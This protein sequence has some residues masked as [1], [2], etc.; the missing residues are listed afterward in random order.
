V[1]HSKNF[2]RRAGRR[3]LV[4]AFVVSTAIVG[5]GIA[6]TSGVG[7]V[8]TPSATLTPIGIAPR[9][10]IGVHPLGAVAPGRVLSVAVALRPRHL[11]ELRAYVDAI[12][13]PSSRLYH[14]YLTPSEFA[15]K[16][17]PPMREVRAI[18]RA[19]HTSH[20][21]TGPV[22]INRLVIPVRGRVSALEGFFHTQLRGYRERDGNYGW[23]ATG[24]PHV[25]REVAPSVSAVIGLDNVVSPHASPLFARRGG[26]DSGGALPA[27]APA[28]AGAP[29]AC[30]DAL[31]RAQSD[32][33]WTE[34][35]IAHAYGLDR[36][37]AEGGLGA[38]QTIDLME[39]EPFLRSDLATFDRCFFGE[40]HT[41]QVNAIPVDGFNLTG[42]GSGESLL[43]VEV[44][45]A[46]APKATIDVYEAPNTSYG[47]IDAY[48]EM[49]NSDSANVISTSWGECETVIQLAAPGTQQVENYLFEE[50]AAQGQTVFAAS[51][52]SGSDDCAGTQFHTNKAEPPYLSVDDPASQP[53]VVAVGG[54]SLRS[55]V[56]PLSAT[57]ERAWN[58]GSNGGGGGGGVSGSW[59]SPAWQVDSGVPG[60]SNPT[61]R[62]VPDVAASA[63]EQYGVTIY[64]ASFGPSGYNPSKGGNED[65]Q[66]TGGTS[67]ASPMWAAIVADI[68]SSRALCPGLSSR[69]GGPDLG[70][71]E[72]ELYAVA[73]ADYSS[74]FHDITD[75]NNDVYGLG[76]GYAAA[77]GFNLVG[78]LGSPIVTNPSGGGGLAR[79]LCEAATGR[80]A[81]LPD[82][83]VTAVSAAS[84]PTGGGNTVTISGSGFAPATNAKV[85]VSFGSATATVQ[86]VTATS[87]SVTVP[88]SP[89]APAAA[90]NDAAGVVDV[91]VT[92]SDAAGASSNVTSR[93]GQYEYFDEQPP[94]TLTPS[95]SGVGPSGGNVA[96]GNRV[97]IY[98]SGFSPGNVEQVT[99]G[100][101]P[102]ESF[103]VVRAGAIGAVV[104]A[105]S[106]Q[107][108]CATGSG[109]QPSTVCQVEVVV[110][111]TTGVS[112][113]DAILPPLIGPIA[114]GP[115]GAYVGQ[116][117]Y[118]T[119][120][121]STEYDYAPSPRI[122]EI[123]PNPTK[124]V[125]N[126]PV[127]ITGS[128]FSILTFDWV[129]FGSPTS[130]NSQQLRI[131][132]LSP[133]AVSIVPPTAPSTSIGPTPLSGGVSVATLAGLTN[134]ATF[135]YAGVPELDRLSRL[136]GSD[137]GGTVLRLEGRGLSDVTSVSFVS[138]LSGAPSETVTSSGISMASPTTLVVATPPHRSGPVAVVPCS[139]AGC[140]HSRRS[141]DTYVYY[142]ATANLA[143]IAP[144]RGVSSGGTVVTLFGKHVREA[145]IVAFGAV[146]S[147]DFVPNPEYPPD[148]PN[149][150]SVIAP[151]GPAGRSVAVIAT[152]RGTGKRERA[153]NPFV[154]VRGVPSAP[155]TISVSASPSSAIV[156]WQPPLSSGG[157]PI[158]GFVVAASSPGSP[159]LSRDLPPNA[160]SVDLSGLA[161]GKTYE[162]SVSAVNRDFGQGRAA[163]AS[164][165]VPA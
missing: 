30:Q 150:V 98:G 1:L 75:G 29:S 8:P 49:V 120:P 17:S 102:A 82:P 113:T 146:T 54:T 143:T 97:E 38:G 58:D 70:F 13:S 94:G 20:L 156:S 104:P 114:F 64:S 50:A 10:P 40:S 23:E 136:G 107:T 21:T 44:L 77:P 9:L 127:V 103:S 76:L 7:G 14:R 137:K 61:G 134:V 124:P 90:P 39:L 89:L 116:S 6:P 135:S 79:L 130:V 105:E 5:A 163:R 162:I 16:F 86:S 43:D 129:N 27:S 131:L 106:A 62:L 26:S 115:Q 157:S 71:V 51:G 147:S 141:V 48:D 72:P 87:L 108:A 119:A 91:V 11:R 47:S 55:D 84:G 138:E 85:A 153:T 109:F 93:A 110:T 133:T 145:E 160:R 63:D 151:P 60:I 140:A 165:K 4:V 34:D 33:G 149:V 112:S 46:L 32:G 144:T 65:W 88:A 158:T 161:S 37:Y 154:F 45:S 25:A 24:A 73:S 3:M 95:V 18:E 148:D 111:T 126:T 42:A 99:F 100:G 159:T 68:A 28:V 132:S 80:L 66:T 101:I 57:R 164:V 92:V 122:S 74:A 139:L 117:G 83:V 53:D 41:S 142:P 118:E 56:Q 69:P 36:L 125:G 12:A 152:L 78:G 15:A 81:S 59:A 128:G 123:T 67:G 35:Q 52:D 121:A 155:R 22:G 19:L 31:M 2:P 96:G